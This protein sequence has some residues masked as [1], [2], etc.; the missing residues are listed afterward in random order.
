[1]I[2]AH[3]ATIPDRL[4][5]LPMVLESLT[6]HVDHIYVALNGHSEIPSINIPNVTYKFCSNQ[7]GDAH[8]F[9][10][11]NEVQ[12]LALITDDDLTWN[13]PAID[14]LRQKA[15]QYK[16]PV[17][18]HGKSYS[19]PFRGFRGFSGNYRCLNTV[20]GDHPVDIIGTGTLMFNTD[21]VKICMSMFPYPNMADVLFSRLCK[22]QGVTLMVAEH[23]AGIIGYL[24]PK[25]TI[26]QNTKS[27][28]LHDKIIRE[29]I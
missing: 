17:S 11:I 1:M 14:L 2:T 6:S 27:Y 16:C 29:F 4:D 19:K 7:F 12:G 15:E 9:E 8:K 26:W 21:M 13:K 28:A 25:T 24:N 18:L 20:I 5:I 3:L 10:F 23:R 22:L